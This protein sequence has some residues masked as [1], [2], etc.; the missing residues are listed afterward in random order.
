[1]EKIIISNKKRFKEIK[2]KIQEEGLE[3]IHVL[4]DFDK[5]LTKAFI[6]GLKIPSII[7]ILRD[8]N[9]LTPDYAEKAHQLYN[10]Y[11]SME[12]NP[13]ISEKERKRLMTEWWNTHFELLIKSGLNK[14]DIENVVDSSKIKFRKGF[15]E[16]ADFLK[17]HNI[18]LV[19]MSSSGLGKESISLKLKKEGKLYDNIYII[20]NDFQ[21]D[22]NGKAVAVEKP[23]VH[24]GNKD[25]TLV[26]NFPD[27]FK[28]IKDRK[29]IV[30]LGDSLGDIGMVEGFNYD[31][32]IKIGFL[33]KK[34]KE[35]YEDV[36]DVLLVNNSSLRFVN[37]FF[38]K[39]L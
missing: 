15:F 1:M 34:S 12:D 38:K 31:N 13:N 24:G 33:N 35:K 18:P 36:Y 23:I 29:N 30:L 14:K 22:E 19:I 16:L 7:S 8:G 5:T 21:W 3:K 9:Y 2:K 25:A 27:I 26:K 39:I 20:S 32:L 28:S 6:N 11:N 10:K 37:D 4:A 17:K